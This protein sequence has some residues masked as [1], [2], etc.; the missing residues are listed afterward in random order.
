MLGLASVRRYLKL[1]LGV[2]GAVPAA[3][4]MAL[5]LAL[6]EAKPFRA[7]EIMSVLVG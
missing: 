4:R 2:K 5:P 3:C 6:V 7:S 1:P